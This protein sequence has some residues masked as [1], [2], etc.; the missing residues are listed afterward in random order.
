M[1]APAR[2]PRMPW[3]PSSFYASTRSWP[4]IARAIYRELLD[5]QWDSGGLPNDPGALR[6]M[7]P[8]L[9][10]L[11]HP[12]RHQNSEMSNKATAWLIAQRRRLEVG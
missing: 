9:L 5:T 6:A 3:Y 1:I 11:A 2:M 7:L 8:R 12:D 10:R 4:L